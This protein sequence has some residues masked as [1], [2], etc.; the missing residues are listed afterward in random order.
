[1]REPGFQSLIGRLKTLW[2]FIFQS[3]QRM[4]QSLIGR[5]KTHYI[6]LLEPF[7]IFLQIISFLIDNFSISPFGLK[8]KAFIFKQK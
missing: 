4:F 8:I 6:S 7:V 2:R 1:M 5:L 3:A